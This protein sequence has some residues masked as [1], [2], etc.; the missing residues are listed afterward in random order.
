MTAEC[1]C[2]GLTIGCGRAAETK[3]RREEAVALKALHDRTDTFPAAY[4]GT[5]VCGETIYPGDPIKR[6][7]GGYRGKCC[8]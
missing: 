3:K 4:L 8:L 2:C 7:D 6:A 1:E 5:C